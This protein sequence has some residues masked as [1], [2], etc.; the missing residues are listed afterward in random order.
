M[1]YAFVVAVIKCA[2]IA[3]VGIVFVS[4]MTKKI[5]QYL[6]KKLNINWGKL[7]GSAFYYVGMAV[8]SVMVLQTADV[9]IS[10]LLGVAGV[11]GVAVGFAAKTSVA[12]VISGIFLIAEQVISIGDT[13]E[14]NG[15]TGMVESLDLLSVKIKTADNNFVR[16][17]N[18]NVL[19]KTLVNL[20]YYKK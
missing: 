1:Q 7:I 13:I 9:S 17:S 6:Q 20:S 3:L 4:S 12:N 5:T 14:S 19:N 11:A 8:V 2:I 16:I 18:E 15:I 10:A